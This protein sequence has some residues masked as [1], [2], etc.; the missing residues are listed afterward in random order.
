MNKQKIFS[1]SKQN[2]YGSPQRISP[3]DLIED[4]LEK[5]MG[6]KDF[7]MVH[8]IL[9][10]MLPQVAATME[11]AHKKL[12]SNQ[13]LQSMFSSKP[14]PLPS[15]PGKAKSI[16]QRVLGYTFGA[17]LS[18]ASLVTSFA[19]IGGSLKS[20]MILDLAILYPLTAFSLYWAYRGTKLS[21][22]RKRY[23]TYAQLLMPT[24]TANLETMAATSNQSLKKTIK[25][26]QYMMKEGFFDPSILDIQRGVFVVGKPAV[27]SYQESI[28]M[29]KKAKELSSNHSHLPQDVA[30]V[31]EEGQ[32]YISRFSQNRQRIQDQEVGQSLEKLEKICTNILHRV[33]KSP[34]RLPEIRRFMQYYL[35][36][37]DKLVHSY[38]ELE[39]QA[40]TGENILQTK[41]D[42][43]ESLEL[44]QSA[45][46]NLLDRLFQKDSVEVYSEISAMKNMFHTDGLMEKSVEKES[47]DANE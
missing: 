46:S 35:P 3:W 5:A 27:E 40:V 2:Q 24:G 44:I 1:E 45:F 14:V 11:S 33:E 22:A 36:M 23:Y 34:E 25:D 26:L 6:S 42:I 16:L 38:E 29:E 17:P 8:A 31:I 13:V 39:Q 19:H 15:P 30:S 47:K 43:K 12:K 21:N 10:D 20:F 28:A 18:M 32:G 7:Q 4:S 9:S 41:K 37:T